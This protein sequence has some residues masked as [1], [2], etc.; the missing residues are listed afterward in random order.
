MLN[1]ESTTHHKIGNNLYSCTQGILEQYKTNMFKS[2]LV[3][4]RSVLFFALLN[5]L[6]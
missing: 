1:G 4:R 5:A 2:M 3:Y 6:K